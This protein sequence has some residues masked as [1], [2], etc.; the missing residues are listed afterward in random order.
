[1]GDKTGKSFI[2]EFSHGRNRSYII[3]GEGPQCITNHLVFQHQ[4]TAEKQKSSPSSSLRRYNRLEE[5][6]RAKETFT[7]EEIAAINAEVAV[8]PD[9]PSNPEMAPNRTLWYAQY[10]LDDV[11]LTVKFYLGEQPDPQDKDKVILEYTPPRRY[12][13]NK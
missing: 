10:D 4:Q 6:L 5:S 12:V 7:L 2:F 3:D 1:V 8:P 9:A 11:T 13:L